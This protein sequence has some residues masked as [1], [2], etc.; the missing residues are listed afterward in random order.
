MGN[1][2]LS[3]VGQQVLQEVGR[4]KK[5]DGQPSGRGGSQESAVVMV[6][7]MESV[8]LTMKL[9]RETVTMSPRLAP[10]PEHRHRLS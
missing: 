2:K 6:G 9:N 5:W 4:G 10:S 1:L 8:G 7:V 3:K